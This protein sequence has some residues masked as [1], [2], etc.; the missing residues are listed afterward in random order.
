MEQG[1]RVAL[2][3]NG[4]VLQEETVR[5]PAPIVLGRA[6]EHGLLLPVGEALDDTH[7][8]LEPTPDGW[9]LRFGAGVAGRVVTGGQTCE[10]REGVVL[11][12]PGDYAVVRIGAAAVYVQFVQQEP[13][14]LPAWLPKAGGV[15]PAA[16]ASIAAHLT[17]LLLILSALPDLSSDRAWVE[18]SRGAHVL[19]DLP[20]PPELLP[21]DVEPAPTETSTAAAA[22]E[23]EA[24]QT[25]AEQDAVTVLPDRDGPTPDRISPE[26]GVAM[27][28]ALAMSGDLT[29]VFGQTDDFAS[30]FGTDFATAGQGDVF[31]L[32]PGSGLG[33]RGPGPGGGGGPLG[34]QRAVGGLSSTE[35]TGRCDPREG[36]CQGTIRRR[37]EATRTAVVVR[38]RPQVGTFLRRE[39][40]ERVVRRHSRGIQ[41]CYDRALQGA[42]S[43]SGRVLINW[44]IGL[45]GRV[46]H[47]TVAEDTLE[48]GAVARCIAVEVQR[49]RF[50]TPDGGH[51]AVS[52]PFTFRNSGP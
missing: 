10:Q 21:Q 28:A 7:T 35:G 12:R 41:Y 45:D 16:V 31:V 23:D 39:E 27:D 13:R 14:V 34:S 46:S 20:P 33:I 3:W 47:A 8:L 51:V 1:L 32:G 48:D 26:L 5:R 50:P 43:L 19:M 22:P 37:A 15:G 25:G 6:G 52:Y 2:V 30:S 4:T 18:T 11:L 40:I 36:D 42:P 49:M 24:G 29:S 44:T 17:L 38:E 9:L